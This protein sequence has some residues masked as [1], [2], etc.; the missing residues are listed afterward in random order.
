MYRTDEQVER[1]IERLKADV[2]EVDL[3]H[4]WA[5]DYRTPVVTSFYPRWTFVAALVVPNPDDNLWNVLE[6]DEED[7]KLLSLY[8]QYILERWYY[9]SYIESLKKVPLDIDP[10]F[11]TMTF[12]KLEH[13]WV[14]RRSSWTMGGTY[15][16]SKFDSKFVYPTLLSLL[17]HLEKDWSDEAQVNEKWRAFKEKHNI[18]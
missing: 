14:Y 10:G 9:A 5:V 16:P 12:A 7:A 13:S 18:Q 8:T 2:N 3:T 6:P 1:L 17:D 11:N 15:A 4:P